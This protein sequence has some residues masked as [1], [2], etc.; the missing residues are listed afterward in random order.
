QGLIF[1]VIPP[2]FAYILIKL[3]GRKIGGATGDLL[4]AVCELNQ[5]MFLLSAFLIIKG[6]GGIV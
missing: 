2:V 6:M 3:L 4:G 5:T 1:S